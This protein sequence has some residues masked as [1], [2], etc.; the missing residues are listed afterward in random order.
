MRKA[1]LVLSTL[2]L[3]LLGVGCS[4]LVY[5][6]VPTPYPV[7]YIPTIIALTVQADEAALVTP[8]PVV[9][10][11]EETQVPSPSPTPEV[12]ITNNGPSPTALDYNPT[13]TPGPNLISSSP[14]PTTTPSL[15]PSITTTQNPQATRTRRPTRTPTITPTPPIPYAGVQ[16]KQ[17]GPMSRVASPLELVASLRSVSSGTYRTEIW[18]EPLQPGG[19]PR[20]LYRE[21][22]R[23]ISNPIDWVYLDPEIQFELSRVSEFSQLRVGMYDQS[24][25]A[26]S[27]NSVDL[28][29]L[30]MGPSDYTPSG[31][32]TEPIVIREPTPNHLIQG[33]KVIVSGLVKPSEQVMLAELVTSENIVVGYNQVFLTPDPDGAYVPFTLE[34][35]YN[36]ASGTWVRLQLSESGVRIPGV[37]HLSSMEVYL[38][39]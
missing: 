19:E 21:L 6:P 17:P 14:N 26:V 2:L 1:C 31:D 15:P 4:S 33:G 29:L 12:V 13:S 24:G 5:T 27:I 37:E 20:L 11:L 3:I 8:S 38:S 35:P 23:L 25:R 39:P 28:I 34:V 9:V 36:V 30:S 16:I 22:H 32:L 7:N 10:V 18:I